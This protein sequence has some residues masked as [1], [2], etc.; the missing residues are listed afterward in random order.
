M[1]YSLHLPPNLFVI[2]LIGNQSYYPVEVSLFTFSC[3]V[4]LVNLKYSAIPQFLH[5]IK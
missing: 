5:Q 1:D 2:F 4:L 3:S